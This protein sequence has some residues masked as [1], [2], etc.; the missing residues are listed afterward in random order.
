M[1]DIKVIMQANEIKPS[2][3]AACNNCGWC[4]LTEVCAV[5]TELSGSNELPCKFMKTE[6]NK[7]LCNLHNIEQLRAVLSIGSGCDAK[8]QYEVLSDLR[9]K[10]D[11]I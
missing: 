4:C 8:T 2:Y 1:I 11:T 3:G 7:H 10:N 6:G 9:L 5:G